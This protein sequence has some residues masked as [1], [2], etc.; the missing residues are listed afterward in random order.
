MTKEPLPGSFFVD[1]PQLQ[2]F[3]VSKKVIAGSLPFR[4]KLGRRD[5]GFTFPVS[6]APSFGRA[7]AALRLFIRFRVLARSGFSVLCYRC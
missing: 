6:S 7:P 5:S 3:Q 4:I 1:G 2:V